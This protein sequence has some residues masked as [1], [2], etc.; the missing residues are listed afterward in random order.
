MEPL[1][2]SSPKLHPACLSLERLEADCRFTFSR[3]GGPGGQHRN[4]V[5]TA[6]VAEHLPSG[7]R[8]E[9]NERRSQAENRAIAL[10]RLRLELALSIRST[11]PVTDGWKIDG[12]SPLWKGHT[13]RGRILISESH[14]DFPAMLAELLDA[15]SGCDDDIARL[16][17]PF[18]TSSSQ[19][20]RFLR[21]SPRSLLELN[22]RRA[23]KGL[24][25]LK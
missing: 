3:R 20:I 23:A 25:S 22:R 14:V 15:L 24:H 17:D 18:G 13:V 5:E 6:V 10:Q 1:P 19:L 16:A 4:K 11:E 9:A 12:P 21:K 7:I 8:V 2:P